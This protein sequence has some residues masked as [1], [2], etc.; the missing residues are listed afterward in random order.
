VL[1]A[2]SMVGT[3]DYIA[4][5]VFLQTGYTKACDYWS[6]GVI[7][8]EMLIGY[9]CFCSDTPQ[10]WHYPDTPQVRFYSHLQSGRHWLSQTHFLSQAS[11]VKSCG[12]AFWPHAKTALATSVLLYKCTICPKP[13]PMWHS[14][15]QVFGKRLYLPARLLADQESRHTEQRGFLEPQETYVKIMN[16]RETLVFPPEMPISK[17]AHN[18]ITR[19]SA[20][21]IACWA[22]DMPAT[23]FGA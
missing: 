20:I 7:M 4:P 10:V 22:G 18:L 19:Y 2:Y 23:Q 21:R 12:C 3:P 11:L 15:S 17:E 16:W 8:F 14:Q 5:E 6:M 1:Q 9:P 13:K